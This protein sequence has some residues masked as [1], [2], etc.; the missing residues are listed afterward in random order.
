MA[1]WM[2]H[3]ALSL[4]KATRKKIRFELLPP[5]PP[6]F[7]HVNVGPGR[8]VCEA[9]HVTAADFPQVPRDLKKTVKN[10]DVLRSCRALSSCK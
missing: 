8:V 3:M 5:T 2:T 6:Q 9:G 7:P 4:G 1:A 10:L